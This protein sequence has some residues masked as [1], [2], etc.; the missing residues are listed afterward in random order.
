MNA[1]RW[2]NGTAIFTNSGAIAR[3]YT[4][5]IEA[6]QV[7]V[8]VPIPVP[9]PMFS[10]TGNKASFAGDLNFYGRL[11][12]NYTRRD[13]RCI[14]QVQGRGRLSGSVSNLLTRV[15]FFSLTFTAQARPAFSSSR[16]SRP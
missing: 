11:R 14:C 15:P 1:N 8:N 2:G 6:G 7:G 10:F 4:M 12:Y 16:S 3:K 13:M 5:H 9:L